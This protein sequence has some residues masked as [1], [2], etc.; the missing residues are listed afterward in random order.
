MPSKKILIVDDEPAIIEI[1]TA[2]LE[3][4]GYAVC[5]AGDGV[6][7]VGKAMLEKPDLIIMDVLMPRMTGY[8]ATKKIR[9]VRELENVPVIVISA[10]GSMKEF[11][12]EI[13]GVEFLTKPYNA[14]ELVRRIGVLLGTTVEMKES[15]KDVILVGVEDMVLAKV[16]TLLE[17]LGIHV[18]PALNEEDAVRQAKKKSPLAILSQFWEAD[19]IL[20]PKKIAKELAENAEISQLPLYVFCKSANSM[21]AMKS[22]KGDRLVSYS[23]NADLLK[24]LEPLFRKIA[25]A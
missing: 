15:A 6:E 16:R 21:E 11:F 5:S 8:E 12:S 3:S 19:H 2:R 9:E 24:K 14:Q 7:G 13:A 4:L 23:D 10:R 18:L 17:S 22:F 1:L 25:T 20:D